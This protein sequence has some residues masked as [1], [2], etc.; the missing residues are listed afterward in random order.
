LVFKKSQPI[1]I[2]AIVLPSSFAIR[3]KNQ[4]DNHHHN[5]HEIATKHITSDRIPEVYLHAEWW[6]FFLKQIS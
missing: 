1:P 3:H 2:L 5:K 4:T 6:G